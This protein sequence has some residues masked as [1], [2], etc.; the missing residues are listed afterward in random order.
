M[1]KKIILTGSTGFL[2]KLFIKKFFNDYE[3]ICIGKNEK[4]ISKNIIQ[5]NIDNINKDKLPE[6]VIVL[7]LAT[8]YSK[9][10]QDKLLIKDA[11][12]DFGLK[13][14]DLFENHKLNKF[15][16]TNTMFSFDKINEKYYYTKS[17][18]KFSDVLYERIN[19]ELISELYLE[20]TF[21]RDDSRNKIVPS[22]VE[23]VQLGLSNPVKNKD[24]YFNLTYADDVINVFDK[25]FSDEDKGSKTRLTS[26]YDINIYSIYEYLNEYK[27][28]RSINQDLLEIIDSRY[29]TNKDI[30]KLNKNFNESS[31]FDNL[32]KL[33]V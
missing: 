20:N 13:L 16:Y 21:H 25:I 22:I 15:V 7:H 9:K 32:L 10:H 33:L 31:I 12:I 2:G 18:N 5:H 27:L 30:P 24:E 28:K 11:N 6:E 23:A 14:L 3:I 17:K 29:L 19:S 1:K 4:V 26:M 8:F